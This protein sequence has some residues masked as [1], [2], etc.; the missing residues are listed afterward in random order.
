MRT[1]MEEMCGEE[2]NPIREKKTIAK[3]CGGKTVIWK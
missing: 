3:I 1:S 2:N